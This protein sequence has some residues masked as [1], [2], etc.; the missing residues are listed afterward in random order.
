MHPLLSTLHGQ[1][2][3][4]TAAQL[5]RTFLVFHV[6]ALFL[7]LPLHKRLREHLHECLHII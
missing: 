1:V 5:V 3:S 7:S 6:L 2:G 4:Q